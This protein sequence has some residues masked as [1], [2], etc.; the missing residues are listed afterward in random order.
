MS[1]VET[2]YVRRGNV[3]LEV[4]E[5]TL[6]KYLAD[7]FDLVDTSGKVLKH[8][9]PN[10]PTALKKRY[11]EQTKEIENLKAQ[12]EALEKALEKTKNKS[13]KAAEE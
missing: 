7:G 11:E 4:N 9:A 1:L 13:K 8:G 10:D 12:V 2:Y 3:L 5:N 6:E